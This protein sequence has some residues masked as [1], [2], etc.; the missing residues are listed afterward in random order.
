MRQSSEDMFQQLSF[1][2]YLSEQDANLLKAD[3]VHKQQQIHA[4]QH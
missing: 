1:Q 2:I 4:R 3:L